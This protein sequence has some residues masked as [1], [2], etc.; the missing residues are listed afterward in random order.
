MTLPPGLPRGRV[1]PVPV[2]MDLVS[3]PQ[4]LE[5]REMI[6]P[7]EPHAGPQGQDRRAPVSQG[8]Y[9]RTFA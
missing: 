3:R 4:L 2:R 7:F 9:K 6:H 8:Q 1:S 5:K